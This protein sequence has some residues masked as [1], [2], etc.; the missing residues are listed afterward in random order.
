MAGKGDTPRQVDWQ[1]WDNSPLWKNIGKRNEQFKGNS[2]KPGDVSVRPDKE[3][4]RK[5]QLHD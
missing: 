4:W 5:N 1:K 2:V 3:G